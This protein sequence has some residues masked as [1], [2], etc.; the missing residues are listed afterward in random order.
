MSQ[1]D[2]LDDRLPWLPN[3][4][5]PRRERS[6]SEIARW[7]AA[8]ALLLGAG[9]WLLAESLQREAPR[10]AKP[11]ATSIVRPPAKP[12]KSMRPSARLEPGT[13]S[14]TPAP[15]L[16]PVVPAPIE[17]SPPQSASPEPRP[18]TSP[19]PKPTPQPQ[20]R[21]LPAPAPASAPVAA[22]RLGSV[23]QPTVQPIQRYGGLVQVGAF[24]DLKQ[25]TSIWN[26][27]VSADA[28]LAAVHPSLI[29]NRDWNGQPFYQFQIGTASKGA[30]QAL[31]QSLQSADIRCEVVAIP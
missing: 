12:A 26:D 14:P 4:P 5:E 31:C 7:F 30:S 8:V 29:Q 13:A 24:A 17:I 16:Q 3:E 28:T 27:M 19:A 23:K 18:V 25:A 11:T 2:A 22:P 1:A 6:Q 21:S 15:Q 10:E 20:A 9:Y